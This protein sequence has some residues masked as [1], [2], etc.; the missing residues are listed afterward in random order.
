MAKALAPDGLLKSPLKLV[1][2]KTGIKR[3]SPR[4]A[5]YSLIPDDCTVYGEPFLGSGGVLIGKAPHS[6]EMVNDLSVWPVNYFQ[7]VK[8]DAL[9]VWAGAEPHIKRMNEKYFQALRFQNPCPYT[10][11]FAAA[12][13]YYVINKF[14][15]NGIVRFRKDGKCNS[16]YCKEDTGRGIVDADWLM[17]VRD[18][19]KDVVFCNQDYKQFLRRVPQAPNCIVVLDPPY[20]QVFTKYNGGDCFNDTDHAEMAEILRQA[21]FRWILTINTN[22]FVLDLYKW[23]NIRTNP[24]YWQVSNTPKGRGMRDELLIT[25]Y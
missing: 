9:R 13:W 20:S 5:I 10:E 16:S 8:A 7:M 24:V 17:K 22:E 11:P 21:N 15:M 19:I 3:D 2:A 25:N 1:G 18:R 23:A 14:A 12:S 4:K 6:F